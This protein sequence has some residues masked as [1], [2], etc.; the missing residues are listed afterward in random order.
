MPY[1]RLPN[2]DS[3]RLKALGI[4]FEKGKDLPPFKLAY[5]QGTFQKIQSLLP[6]YENTLSEHKNSYNLHLEKS[7]IFTKTLKKVRLYISHFIQVVNMS[8]LRGEL[9]LDTREYF[10]FHNDGKK[11]PSLNTNEEVKQW[12]KYLIEGEQR[13]MMHGLSPITN[14][15]IAVVKVQWDKFKDAEI[16]QQSLKK[17][18]LRAQDNLNGVRHEVD[19]VIQKLWNEVEDTYKDLPENLKRKKA[20]EYGVTYVFR[21]NELSNISILDNPQFVIN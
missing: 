3:A 19:S 6:G 13:R 12:A 9:P 15:T 5:K 1:R 11:L 18:Y 20:S 16:N 14:P 21:K 2:T 10:N 17:R 8:I 4:A 7:K